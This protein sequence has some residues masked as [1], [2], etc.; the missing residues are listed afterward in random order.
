LVV[1][2]T[3]NFDMATVQV[4]VRAGAGGVL[5]IGAD[6]PPANLA[7]ELS[8]ALATSGAG[9]APAIM[10]DEEGGGIQRLEGAVTSVPWARQMAQ[11]MSPAQVEALAAD[12]G[13]GMR[14]LGV[15]V[16][17]APV[18]DLDDR[19]GPNATNPDGLRSFSAVP[20]IAAS[21]GVAFLQGLRS[22]GV[23]AVVKHFPGL[24][25]ASGNTDYGLASTVPLAQLQV[26]GLAP[27]RAAIAADVPA[28][29]VSNASVPGLTNLPASLSPAAIDGLLRHSLGFQGLVLT[30]SLSAGAVAQAGYQL[31]AAA[32]TAI[33]AGADMILFGSTLTPAET[34]LLS[35][36]N[37]ATSIHEIVD[38]IV[39]ATAA[40]SLPIDR[41]NNAVEHVLEAKDINLCA[42]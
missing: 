15:G 35:P 25:G 13:R 24:G 33:E 14:Q 5:L 32:A 19:P 12:V 10:A 16:D 20:S 4:A 9:P 39:S 21:Y 26:A 6:R 29:M 8:A 18:V 3:L 40:G 34:V 42:R 31:P 27:F 1:A 36:Q 37:V 28:I 38:A 7:A 41:L 17:L 2:P 23:L 11:T 22:A 30:D